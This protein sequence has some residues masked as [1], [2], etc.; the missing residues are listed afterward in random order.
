MSI[1]TW[2]IQPDIPYIVLQDTTNIVEIFKILSFK[3]LS[4][5]KEFI[6]SQPK[7]KKKLNYTFIFYII[8]C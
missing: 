1:S 2:Y 3:K 5:I 8:L 4:K 6:T 7:I